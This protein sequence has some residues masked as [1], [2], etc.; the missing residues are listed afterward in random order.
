VEEVRQK[1]ELLL[2]ND[3][4]KNRRVGGRKVEV[5]AGG[6]DGVGDG[7]GVRGGWSALHGGLRRV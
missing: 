5:G 4:R 2:G 1:V 7:G 6:V 3:G